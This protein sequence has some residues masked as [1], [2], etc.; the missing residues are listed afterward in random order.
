MS[1]LNVMCSLSISEKGHFRRMQGKYGK[2]NEKKTLP[3]KLKYLDTLAVRQRSMTNRYLI[4]DS[5]PNK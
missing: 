3:Y 2:S 4:S 5:S 1:L